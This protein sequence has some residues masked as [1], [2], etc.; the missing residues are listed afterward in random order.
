[1]EKYEESIQCCDK[2]L[3]DY[4]KNEDVL[5]DKS[6][7]LVMN[8]KIDESLQILES[9]IIQNSK[10]KTKAA[11]SKCFEQLIENSTFQKLISN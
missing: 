4:P 7:S 11:Q 2:I 9:A 8:S 6:C 5:F 10:F 3:E 1:M